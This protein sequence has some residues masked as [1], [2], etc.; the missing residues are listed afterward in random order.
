MVPAVAVWREPCVPSRYCTLN[1]VIL[2]TPELSGTTPMATDPPSLGLTS[3]GWKTPGWAHRVSLSDMPS[4][5]CGA[6]TKMKVTAGAESRARIGLMAVTVIGR[7][8]EMA[9]DT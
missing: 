4:L 7:K 1:P 8:E 2:T 3:T 9:G 6:H 5:L